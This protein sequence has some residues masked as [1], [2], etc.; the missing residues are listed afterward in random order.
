MFSKAFQT[1]WSYQKIIT[2]KEGRVFLAGAL[3]DLMQSQCKGL[4]EALP[5]ITA[6]SGP[7]SNTSVSWSRFLP[8]VPA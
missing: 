7:A 6:L 8:S 2:H 1:L 4:Q 5:D 3:D